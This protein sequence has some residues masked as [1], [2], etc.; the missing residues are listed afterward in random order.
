MRMLQRLSLVVLT[1]ASGVPALA[2]SD[3]FVASRSG[4]IKSADSQSGNF[5]FIGLCG[6]PV[7]SM[8]L[9]GRDLLLGDVNGNI[10]RYSLDDDALSYYFTVAGSDNTAMVVHNSVL[11]AADADGTIRRVNATTGQPLGSLRAPFDVLAMALDG[12]DLFIA[13]SRGEVWK[14][15]PVTGGFA[16]FGCACFGQINGLTVM[17][18]GDVAV[19]DLQGLVGRFRRSDG[20]LTELFFVNGA[21]EAVVAEGSELLVGDASG[22]VHR[23]NPDTGLVARTYNAGMAISSMAL[24]EGCAGD[25][26]ADG[27][28]NSDDYFDYLNAYY[29]GDASADFDG[30]GVVDSDDFFDFHNSYVGG[31]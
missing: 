2:A 21:H 3:L 4:Q 27:T 7:D 17:D 6:G 14:G 20:Q 16:Y 29:A 22:T 24:N 25:F 11:L 31:C 18:S 1:A 28:V 8:T 15:S 26:N 19:V 30:N 13:G 12:N 23:V 10:Y 9:H 5:S